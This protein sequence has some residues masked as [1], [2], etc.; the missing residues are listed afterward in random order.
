[1]TI[2]R[3]RIRL[4]CS[5]TSHS[6]PTYPYFSDSYDSVSFIFG[7][8]SFPIPSSL[9]ILITVLPSGFF[10]SFRAAV[11]VVTGPAGVAAA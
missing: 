9:L 8:S 3:A 1:M 5:D 10:L 6:L 7:L 11:A 2:G 4:A